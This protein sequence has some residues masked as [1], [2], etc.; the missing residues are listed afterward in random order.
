MTVLF[1]D[2]FS[3]ALSGWSYG[4]E[5][6]PPDTASGVLQLHGPTPAFYAYST[7]VTSTFAGPVRCS[8]WT[9]ELADVPLATIL[10]GDFFSATFA[11]SGSNGQFQWNLRWT[12]STVPP[13]ETPG[14]DTVVMVYPSWSTF[15]PPVTA[16]GSD[17]PVA[18][19]IA[20]HKWLRVRE[21]CHVIGWDVSSDGATWVEVYTTAIDAAYVYESDYS[22]VVGMRSSGPTPFTM[23]VE[24]V[25]V[26]KYDA[27]LCPE[28]LGGWHV[29]RAA[30]STSGPW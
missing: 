8:V 28:V 16:S 13:P 23:D 15:F 18:F 20:D 11:A 29:G 22:M 1:S 26:E 4:A 6:D 27:C 7:S 24:G 19:D 14:T 12:P 5:P 21:E 3:S 10:A 2:D 9:W 30:M 17:T 25:S